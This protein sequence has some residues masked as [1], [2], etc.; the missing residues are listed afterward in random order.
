[1]KRYKGESKKK[2]LQIAENSLSI[3]RSFHLSDFVLIKNVR[4]VM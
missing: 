2:H 4:F 3:M 1:M